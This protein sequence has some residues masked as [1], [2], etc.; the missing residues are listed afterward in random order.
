M[1]TAFLTRRDVSM[2]RLSVS[3]NLDRDSAQEVHE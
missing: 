2:P 3:T 1:P